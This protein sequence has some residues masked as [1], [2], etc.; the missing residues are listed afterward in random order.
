LKGTTLDLEALLKSYGEDAPSGEDLEYDPLF[1]E[2]EIAAQPSE[3]RQVGDQIIAAEDPNYKEVSEKAVN[4]LERSH[5]LRA[6]VFW[7]AAE[8][9]LSGY[10]GFSKATGYIS[11]CLETYW[12]TCHPQLDADDEDD[13]TMRVNAILSLADERQILRGVRSAPLT[14]SRM[15]G[16]FSLRDIS[17][18]EGEASPSLDMDQMPELS[19]IAAA[20]KDTDQDDLQE[21]SNAASK[22]LSDVKKISAKFDQAT[23]G[24]GPDLTPL[25]KILEKASGKLR[26]ALGDEVADLT[27]TVDDS[28]GVGASPAVV[29][30]GEISSP[31][32]VQNSLNKIILYYERY[33]PSSPLP[34]LLTR[35][36]KLVSADFLTIVRDMAPNGVD[37][38]NLIGGLEDD[39]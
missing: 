19:Q 27:I 20:F 9:R 24:F 34:L 10:V 15:F 28:D 7:A 5:D 1:A 3:E 32:D 21:I 18:A 6:A 35:A 31:A 38:V 36:K 17:L 2:L 13:P 30:G 33:E 12:D 14:S 11:G 25:L 8:L 37:N 39:D 22:A 16:A 23:P 4:I 29:R 26:G